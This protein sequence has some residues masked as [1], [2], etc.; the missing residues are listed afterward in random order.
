MALCVMV[1]AFIILM[2]FFRWGER[3]TLYVCT[4]FKRYIFREGQY[5]GWYNPRLK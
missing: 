5:V 2:L 4:P 1:I 3:D